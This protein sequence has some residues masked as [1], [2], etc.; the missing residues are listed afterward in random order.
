ML[1]KLMAGMSFLVASRNVHLDSATVAAD[2]TLT[3]DARAMLENVLAIKMKA[4]LQEMR[5]S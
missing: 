5:I 1:Q 2:T 4:I 3:D